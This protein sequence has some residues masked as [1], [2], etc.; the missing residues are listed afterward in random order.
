MQPQPKH[1]SRSYAEQFQEASVVVA[2]AHRPPI[3]T[4]VFTIL[5]ALI[6][7]EP[8]VVLD[9]GCGAGAVARALMPWTFRRP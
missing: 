9:A 2:Y 7:D 8:R 5:R 1:L 6:V 4:P 3:P